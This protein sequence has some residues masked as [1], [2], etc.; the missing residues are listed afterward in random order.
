MCPSV[1]HSFPFPFGDFQ[2]TDQANNSAKSTQL[3]FDSHSG[4]MA[5]TYD[6]SKAFL[7]S[8]ILIRIRILSLLSSFSYASTSSLL[9]LLRILSSPLSSPLLSSP[10][11]P[12]N[13]PIMSDPSDVPVSDIKK[14]INVIVECME[15]SH[16]E[17][18]S[19]IGLCAV[20]SDIMKVILST[21]TQYRVDVIRKM[22]ETDPHLQG[23]TH[24][25]NTNTNKTH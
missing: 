20:S 8:P 24:T 5:H 17:K 6:N 18:G 15:L 22:I 10:L 3:R 19:A 21:P 4:G 16:D 12:S 2:W 14:A 13:S 1:S 11:P 7:H 9:F 23:Q 25:T